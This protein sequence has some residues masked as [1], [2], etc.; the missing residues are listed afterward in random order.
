MSPPSCLKAVSFCSKTEYP[1]SVPTLTPLHLLFP[2]SVNDVHPMA[3]VKD[4]AVICD[5]PS[6]HIHITSI[7]NSSPGCSS[8]PLQPHSCNFSDTLGTLLLHGHCTDCSLCLIS[9][10]LWY[11]LCLNVPFSMETYLGLPATLF[12]W[13]TSPGSTSNLPYSAHFFVFILYL[14][15]Q[16][17]TITYVFQ[18]T[19]LFIFQYMS[20]LP[21]SE[22]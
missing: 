21:E 11:P 6:S 20:F 16:S 17:Y 22:F 8:A 1:I 12:R 15:L 7:R 13:Q 5:Y 2:I 18:Y 4:L 9:L 10:P 19:S 3:E 14:L